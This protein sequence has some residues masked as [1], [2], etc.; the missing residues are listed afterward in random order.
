MEVRIRYRE[1]ALITLLVQHFCKLT[2]IWSVSAQKFVVVEVVDT[3]HV[4]RK[5]Q[6]YEH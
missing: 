6:Y 4:R 3:Q 5:K 1:T 2:I